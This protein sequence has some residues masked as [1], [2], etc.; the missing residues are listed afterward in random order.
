MCEYELKLKGI[1]LLYEVG[2]INFREAERKLDLAL[3]DVYIYKK[4]SYKR[5]QKMLNDKGFVR[6]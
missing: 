6:L 4:D 2:E 5:L 1:L 3:E